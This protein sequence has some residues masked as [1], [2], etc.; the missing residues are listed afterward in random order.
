MES[1]AIPDRQV[2]ASSV[3]G[4]NMA[5]SQGRLQ[6]QPIGNK[7]EGAWA[8]KT[9]NIN[10]WLQVDLGRTHTTVTRVATQGRP[11]SGRNQ[12]VTKYKLQY[13]DDGLNA[14]YFRKHGQATVKVK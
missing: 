8:A 9:S 14:Y 4:E 7:Y 3:F 6:L 1:G 13:S 10:Q 5:A 11:E 2:S 12:W